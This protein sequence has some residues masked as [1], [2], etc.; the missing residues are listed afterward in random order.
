[1][2]LYLSVCKVPNPFSVARVCVHS[3]FMCMRVCMRAFV[4]VYTNACMCACV[5]VCV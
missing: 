3:V 1:M 2:C 5:C 4:Y